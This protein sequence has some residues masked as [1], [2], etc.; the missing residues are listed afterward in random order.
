MAEGNSAEATICRATLFHT[1]IMT[2]DCKPGVNHMLSVIYNTMFEAAG[3]RVPMTSLYEKLR[4]TEIGLREGVVPI[5]L[6]HCI[7]GWGISAVFYEGK[8]EIPFQAETVELVNENPEKYDLYIERGTLKRR[9]FKETGKSFSSSKGISKSGTTVYQV[10]KNRKW[11]AILVYP[12]A[13]FQP[14]G[15]LSGRNK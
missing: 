4:G 10:G 2:G 14:H 1:G 8:K 15:D 3:K 9:L 5:Y 13:G 11:T 6:A 12:S 7:I